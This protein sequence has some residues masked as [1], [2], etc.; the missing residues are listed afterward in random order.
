M[1]PSL[2]EHKGFLPRV[3]NRFYRRTTGGVVVVVVVVVI[4]VV[5]IIILVAPLIKTKKR[6]NIQIK[7]RS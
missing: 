2:E 4:V 3:K 5:L 1:L 7:Y 6:L